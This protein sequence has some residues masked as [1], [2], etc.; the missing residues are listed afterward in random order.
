M[1]CVE[2]GNLRKSF[3]QQAIIAGISLEIP[4]DTTTAIVGESGSGKTTLLQL[5]NGLLKPDS[6]MVR[7]FGTPLDYGNLVAARRAM[8]YA[9]Q[10]AGLFPHMTVF[11]NVTIVARL[12][13]WADSA[14]EE[15]YRHLLTL[16]ELT[17][18]FSNRYPHS[19]SGGQQQRVSLCRAMMLNPPLL[20]LDEPFS[21]LDPITRSAIHEQFLHLQQQEPRS[22]VFVTHDMNEARDLAQHGVIMRQGD[23]LQQGSMAAIAE[24]PADEYV[25]RLFRGSGT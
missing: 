23:V 9:V 7:I 14:I 12:A 13:G 4:A 8:G 25:E 20:L 22:V 6:G 10:G 19:L 24:N 2:F 3:G 15:R 17:D 11:D 18:E 21:A 5:V 1:S 16:L